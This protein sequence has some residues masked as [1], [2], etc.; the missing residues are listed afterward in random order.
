MQVDPATGLMRR[1]SPYN[2]AFD[3]PIRFIDPDG[4]MPEDKVEDQCPGGPNCGTTGSEV[5]DQI[6]PSSSVSQKIEEGKQL[7]NEAFTGFF[8]VDASI[9]VGGKLDVGPI[10]LEGEANLISAGGKISEDKISR[11][12][13]RLCVY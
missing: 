10:K 12:C 13:P 9:G 6:T 5:V 11:Y 7:L 8:K 1:H 3:N 2:Y 4:M